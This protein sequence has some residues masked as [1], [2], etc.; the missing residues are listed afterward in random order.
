[1]CKAPVVIA[2]T[3]IL[4]GFLSA[5]SAAQKRTG[6]EIMGFRASANQRAA[7]KPNAQLL[8]A[9]PGRLVGCLP[10]GNAAFEVT[11][12][13]LADMPGNE[14]AVVSMADGLAIFSA[15]GDLVARAPRTPTFNCGVSARVVSMTVGQLVADSDAELVVVT[16]DGVPNATWRTLTIFKRRGAQLVSIFSGKIADAHAKKAGVVEYRDDGTLMFR[17]PW[18]E[19]STILYWNPSTFHFSPEK[20]MIPREWFTR[21]LTRWDMER[22]KV[23]Q[24][25]IDEGKIEDGDCV[26]SAI[27]P[28]NG[29]ALCQGTGLPKTVPF[30]VRW[31][32]K[33]SLIFGKLSCAPYPELPPPHYKTKSDCEY[34]PQDAEH[35]VVFRRDKERVV[36]HIVQ[37]DQPSARDLAAKIAQVANVHPELDSRDFRGHNSVS[38]NAEILVKLGNNNVGLGDA[39]D[40]KVCKMELSIQSIGSCSPAII[41]YERSN[42]GYPWVPRVKNPMDVFTPQ[43]PH[44]AKGTEV[45][46]IRGMYGTQNLVVVSSSTHNE[47][48]DCSSRNAIG[49]VEIFR[50]SGTQLRSFRKIEFTNNNQRVPFGMLT[51][52]ERF[53]LVKGG[54]AAESSDCGCR[55][56]WSPFHLYEVETGRWVKTFQPKRKRQVKDNSDNLVWQGFGRYVVSSAV[57]STHFLFADR[58]G[59]LLALSHDLSSYELN[60]IS[61][62]GIEAFAVSPDGLTIA[63]ASPNSQEIR[64][65]R[66]TDGSFDKN[67]VKELTSLK[68]HEASVVAVAF[69]PD[70]RYLL[71]SGHDHR[72][73]VWDVQGERGLIWSDGSGSSDS[74]KIIWDKDGILYSVDHGLGKVLLG[75]FLDPRNIVEHPWLDWA[76]H[77]TLAVPHANVTLDWNEA[78]AGYVLRVTNTGRGDLSRIAALVTNGDGRP[79]AVALIG[80]V[81]AQKDEKLLIQPQQ[82]AVPLKPTGDTLRVFFSEGSGA[83]IAPLSLSVTPEKSPT[84]RPELSPSIDDLGSGTSSGNGNGTA[85]LGAQ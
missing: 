13:L 79:V 2:A 54:C 15:G 82:F 73:R 44:Y 46:S 80:Y 57:T 34:A 41:A 35:F 1:M 76:M 77:P 50:A 4:L 5:P 55:E 17:A 53:L 85:D 47:P 56:D 68:G 61:P 28:A 42:S 64:L 70:G 20:S 18:E 3:M 16:L 8:A 32:G 22:G 37:V 65:L 36:L 38:D 9:Q 69:S 25:N 66:Y 58:D 26:I 60:N 83:P 19:K 10:Q 7:S 75:P 78:L 21:V 67:H 33:K 40:V 11:S 51:P 30:A 23:L 49:M 43:G 72:L 14:T 71:S 84:V 59:Y 29:H 81:G 45:L 6:Q 62:E 52:D 48:D 39:N 63:M 24:Y 12:N 74:K 31:E 27:R